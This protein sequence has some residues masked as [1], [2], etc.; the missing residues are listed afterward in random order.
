MPSIKCNC[1]E[2]LRYGDIPNPIEWLFISDKD[3]DSYSGQIDSE[4]LYL[5]MNSMLLCPNCNGILIFWKG[6]NHLPVY[7][8][9]VS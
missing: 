2:L 7:Y 9:P 6:F 4:A 1:G 3:Y 5:H 8:K